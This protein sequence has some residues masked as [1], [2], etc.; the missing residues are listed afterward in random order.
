MHEAAVYR[1]GSGRTV[2]LVG[3][4]VDDLI[5]TGADQ[6]EV[7]NFKAAMRSTST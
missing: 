5:I 3:I 6:G 7:E 2:L 1:R 4:Y